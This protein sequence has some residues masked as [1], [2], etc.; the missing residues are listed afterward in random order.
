MNNFIN[1]IKLWQNKGHSG[2]K[3]RLT[4]HFGIVVQHGKIYL[5]YKMHKESVVRIGNIKF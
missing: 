3:V 1:K 5:I 2:F 4:G